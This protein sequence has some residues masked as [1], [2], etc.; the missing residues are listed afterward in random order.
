MNKKTLGILLCIVLILNSMGI[1]TITS[2]YKTSLGSL[3]SPC[4][5]I[6]KYVECPDDENWLKELDV[7][8]G[9]TVRFWITVDNCGDYDLEDVNIVDSLPNELDYLSG[10]ASPFNPE[11]QGNK[12]IWSF[13]PPLQPNET[14][15]IKFDAIV[16]SGGVHI[17]EVNVSTIYDG[18]PLYDEDNATINSTS[19]PT[20]NI[21]KW[22]WDPE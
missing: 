13:G 17:N 6:D 22:V 14:I 7:L 20:V 1:L 11:I 16:L 8:A 5:S 21:E 2:A 12:L 3:D 4:V 18:T 9:E 15:I 19:P 10:S